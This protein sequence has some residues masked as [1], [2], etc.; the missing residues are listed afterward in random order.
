MTDKPDDSIAGDVSQQYAHPEDV[1]S[2]RSLTRDQK[3]KTLQ[4][5]EQDLRQL[6]VASE[7]NMPGTVTGQPA[8]SLQAVSAALTELGVTSEQTRESPAKT[9]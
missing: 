9:G 7:E 2:D 6:M 5:W 3:I 1:L 4:E 8:E